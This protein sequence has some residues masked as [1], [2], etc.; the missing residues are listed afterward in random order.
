M[1]RVMIFI[2]ANNFYH[3]TLNYLKQKPKVDF[4]KLSKLL[5]EKRPNRHLLR[6]YFYTVKTSQQSGIIGALSSK[7]RFTVVEGTLQKLRIPGIEFN[8]NDP[9][10]FVTVEKKTDVNLTTD[11]LIGAYMNSY[12]TAI[13]VSGDADYEKPIKE[14]KK[15]GKVV[16]VVIT[17][18][19]PTELK[20]WADEV[21]Q[22][23]ENDFSQ[24][25]LGPFVSQK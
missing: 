18:N 1:E 3:A 16:E 21:F 11:L 23:T 7:P 10:T 9:S 2:D 17:E 25:W 19:Q 24:C 12:D 22:L 14:I 6:T 15:L 13:L 4:I 20:K 8:E 5:V